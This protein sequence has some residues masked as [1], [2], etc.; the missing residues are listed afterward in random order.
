MK[1][2][3]AN[4][5]AVDPITGQPLPQGQDLGNVPTDEDPDNNAEKY[6]EADGKAAEI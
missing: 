4:P 6:T 5:A 2:I 1:G 3:I